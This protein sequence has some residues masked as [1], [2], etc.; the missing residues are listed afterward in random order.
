MAQERRFGLWDSP[1]TTDSFATAAVGLQELLVDREKGT[2]VHIE[3]RPAEMGRNVIIAHTKGS[4]SK[5]V[6]VNPKDTSARSRVHEYG[7]A[8]AAV[9]AGQCVFTDA[10]DQRLFLIKNALSPTKPIPLTPESS[11][12][13]YADASI[14]PSLSHLVCVQENHLSEHE[15]INTLVSVSLNSE[16][17][18]GDPI[19]VVSG[20]DF[21]SAPR[22]SADGRHLA[23]IQWDLPNMPWTKSNLMVAEWDSVSKSPRN[24]RI[25]AGSDFSVSQPRWGLPSSDPSGLYFASDETNFYNLYRHDVPSGA[26]R[27][28]LAE[29]I[30][31]DFSGPDW[32]LGASTYDFLQDGRVIAAHSEGGVAKISIIDSAG[33]TSLLRE[34]LSV[35]ALRTIDDHV[36]VIAGSPTSSLQILSLSSSNGSVLS[37]LRESASVDVDESFISVAEPI[38]FPTEEEKTAYAYLYRPKNPNYQAPV[39]TLPPLL[40]QCHGGPTSA[41]DTVLKLSLQY[42]TSRGWAVCTVNYGGSSGYGREYRERLDGKWGIVDVADVCNAALHLARQGIVNPGQL[43]VSGGS[44]GGYTVLAACA[45]RPDVFAAGTSSYGI[46]DLVSLA[47]LTH[48]FESRYIDGLLGGNVKDI[49]EIY[50]ARSP[51]HHVANVQSPMLIL[52]GSEDRVVPPNQAEVMVDAVRAKGGV[53]EYVIFEGEGHGWRKS[54]NIKTACETEMSFYLKTLN[55]L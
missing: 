12:K 37:V 39:G 2:L 33:G 27:P 7:G 42:W 38:E 5:L 26:T 41:Y 1:I 3:L 8:P 18:P 22:F 53:V 10:V 19:E 24:I 31:G 45:F 28:L 14:H 32:V 49:E 30:S 6:E 13:R 4:T 35:R 29:P 21:Y 25:I 48:K 43:C 20:H 11:T 47:Q 34:G 46:C 52:Q 9:L 15:I 50:K 16:G 17:A 23:W 40:V 44:A 55:I 36:F 54:E 51:I